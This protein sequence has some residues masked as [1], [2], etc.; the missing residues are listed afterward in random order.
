MYLKSSKF[1]ENELIGKFFKYGAC[2]LT[3]T[4]FVCILKFKF[5]TRMF[6]FLTKSEN[7]FPFAEKGHLSYEWKRIGMISIN[8]VNNILNNYLPSK[9][10]TR[11]IFFKLTLTLRP[12]LLISLSINSLLKIPTSLL[13]KIIYIIR[14]F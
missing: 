9:E 6:T 2:P 1:L 7:F 4:L 3:F 5:L 14:N 13:M 8:F 11:N 12:P 10:N